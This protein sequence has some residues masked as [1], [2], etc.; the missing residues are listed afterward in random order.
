MKKIV[1]INFDEIK[2]YYISIVYTATAS[3]LRL[4]LLHLLQIH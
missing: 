2:T 1:K 4:D 3:Y